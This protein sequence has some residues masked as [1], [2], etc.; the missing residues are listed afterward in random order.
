MIRLKFLNMFLAM[1]VGLF[2]FSAVTSECS[3]TTVSGSRTYT[4]ND[5]SPYGGTGG[6]GYGEKTRVTTKQAAK[7]I[8]RDYFSKKN[9]T[10]GEIRDKDIYF[11]ADILDRSGK[12]IDKVVVDKRT[13]RIRSIY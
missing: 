12:I 1:A 5:Q 7:E 10:I 8:L 11:E 3:E 9:V 4:A 6:D 2:I 13:G